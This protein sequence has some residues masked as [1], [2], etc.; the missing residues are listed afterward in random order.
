VILQRAVE[1][2]DARSEEQVLAAL[3]PLEHALLPEAVC[4]FARGE[5][6]ID[7]A[8]PRRPRRAR[9]ASTADDPS[10]G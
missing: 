8:D 7:P 4:L 5:L 3:R 6:A 2:A 1:L 10:E 9:A